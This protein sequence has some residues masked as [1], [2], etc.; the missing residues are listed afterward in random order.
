MKNSDQVTPENQATPENQL[1]NTQPQPVRSPY[2]SQSF[3]CKTLASTSYIYSFPMPPHLVEDGCNFTINA[4][5]AC[6]N[7]PK[8]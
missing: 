8:K 3:F 6:F 1:T 7:P 2:I 4:L 5:N